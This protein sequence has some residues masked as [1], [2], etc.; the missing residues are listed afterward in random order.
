VLTRRKKSLQTA[1]KTTLTRL[2][3]N[4]IYPKCSHLGFRVQFIYMP[5]PM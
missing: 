5:P 1:V 4:E 2:T 3:M